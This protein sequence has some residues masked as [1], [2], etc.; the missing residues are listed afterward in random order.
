MYANL[1]KNLFFDR[2]PQICT[3]LFLILIL[4]AVLIFFYNKSMRLAVK[5]DTST[6]DFFKGEHCFRK[7]LAF[8]TLVYI[9]LCLLTFSPNFVLNRMLVWKTD[10]VPQYVPYLQY[11]GRY[12]RDFFSDILHGTVSLRM[13]DFNIGMGSDIC[14]VFRMHILDLLPFRMC[15]GGFFFFPFCIKAFLVQ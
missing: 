10:A 1:F 11:I 15:T 4:F 14:T 13:Y 2:L 3:L 7:Y 12:L 8:Y 9:I 6:F 5:N